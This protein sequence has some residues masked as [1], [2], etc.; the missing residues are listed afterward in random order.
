MVDT[1]TSYPSQ[2]GRIPV[3]GGCMTHRR[4]TWSLAVLVAALA[5]FTAACSDV[6]EGG[7]AAGDGGAASTADCGTDTVDIAVN[8]WTGSA[9]NANVAKVIMEKELGCTVELTEI[10]EFGQF[11]ALS[12]GDLDATLEVWPSG[13]AK[14]YK[15][16]IDGNQ[17]IVDGGELG[18][19]GQIGWFVPQYMV[20]QYPELA[21]WEGLN[22]NADLFATAETGD[23]GQFLGGDPSFVSY[24]QQII[25]NL[26]LD[27][28]V[29]YAGSEAAELT[30]LKQAY[31][32]EEPLLLYFYK[33]HWAQLK[34]PMA[35]VTL[36]EYTDACAEAAAGD[37][38]AYDCGYPEDVL[39]KAFNEDLAT[40]SPAAFEFLGNMNYENEMQESVA[41]DIDVNG[42]TPEEAA[43]KWVDENQDVWQAW[44]PA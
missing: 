4:R 14:D 5:L 33:P 42:M 30:A 24:D 25:D 11:P 19:I 17:G 37:A 40:A 31:K 35:Q 8:P 27:Y 2:D 41:L 39:Y 34:Y 32:N 7:T 28:K 23:Q 38:K 43:Q 16:Y 3:K 18:V 21:T 44:L 29:V 13:H 12:T 15:K 26:G 10:D 36:P 6:D 9:V 20:D 22:A 1:R